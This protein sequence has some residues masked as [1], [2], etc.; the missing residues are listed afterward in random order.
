MLRLLIICLISS[1]LICLQIDACTERVP[2]MKM[3]VSLV[4]MRKY[5]GFTNC[6]TDCGPL[7]VRPIKETYM[8][9]EDVC[10]EGYERKEENPTASGECLPKCHDCGANGKCLSP[11]VCL[12]DQGYSNRANRSI[13]Q[14]VCSEPCVKGNCVA[15]DVCQCANNY[16]LRNNSL[17]VCQ[18]VCKTSECTN[19]ICQEDGSCQCR[20]GYRRNA[21]LDMCVPDC[22]NLAEHSDC[23]APNE[24]RC[25]EGYEGHWDREQ[26][27][28]CEPIC[29]SGCRNGKCLEPEHCA[30]NVGFGHVG[31]RVGAGCE[32]ICQPACINGTCAA[33]NH[34]LCQPGHV[35][36]NASRHICTPSC[37]QGCEN[38]VC[39]APGECACNEGYKKLTPHRCTASCDPPCG[40]NAR[41]TA[42][43][44]CSCDEG[45]VPVNGSSTQ[46]EPFC[47]KECYNGICSNPE[48][49]TCLNG[50][51]AI[52]PYYCVAKCRRSCVFGSC[53]APDKCRCFNGHR[54]SARDPFVCE[55]ICSEPCGH[56]RC[57]A[58]EICE[59]EPGYAKRWPSG[60]CEPYCSQKCINSRCEGGTG[61]CRCYEGY[62][63]REGSSSICD[64]I[65]SPSC[66]NGTCVEP[67][68]CECWPG[69]EDTK[70]YYECKPSCRPSCQ[71]G[72]CVAPGRCE[73]NPGFT[74]S[75]ASEPHVCRSQ[76]QERCINAECLRP[77]Q[78][79]CLAGY[80][81]IANSRSECAPDCSQPCDE[82]SVCVAPE[83]CERRTYRALSVDGSGGYPKWSMLCLALL[84]CLFLLMLP[85]ILTRE[86]LQRRKSRKDK[87]R[88][89]LIENPSYGVCLA[90]SEELPADQ[91]IGLGD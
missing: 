71:N 50:Y 79:I 44:T 13:C 76:C 81:F 91:Q 57:I 23:I 12:C 87:Q 48:V 26:N 32:P 66:S 4:T 38:G 58:P 39:S 84:L 40:L 3:K 43:D 46:C 20:R 2:M 56:G 55:P 16:R 88:V 80:S 70:L 6:T 67:N 59:C 8:S 17:S 29:S 68:S 25:H 51:E 10:C 75:N 73:C 27:Y 45:F 41:C 31:N 9:L 5:H 30:C 42:P 49:C 33:P 65:C 77:N 34:C 78:C 64:P 89:H 36:M 47:S 24:Q 1:L 82:D 61:R 83:I 35:P 60:S 28:R 74:A 7:V 69:Y 54:P 62:R 63:L 21:T 86:Y 22:P 90:A 15:P 85:M 72:R 37:R 14:P 53:V 11:E 19:G 52:S 18:P